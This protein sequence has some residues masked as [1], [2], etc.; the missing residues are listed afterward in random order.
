MKRYLMW[1]RVYD[2]KD[3]RVIDRTHTIETAYDA[4]DAMFRTL[5]WVQSHIV[6]PVNVSHISIAIVASD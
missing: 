3:E 5:D 1:I 2:T 6:L 4:Q